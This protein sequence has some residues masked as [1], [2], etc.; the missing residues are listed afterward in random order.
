M[1]KSFS[2][3][4]LGLFFSGVFLRLF[5]SPDMNYET[6]S[7]SVLLASK[8]LF[9]IG[10]YTIPPISLT[11]YG[12]NYQ[13]NPGWAVGYSLLLSLLFKFFGYSESIARLT[14]ILIT[15]SV[16]PI[17]G[18]VGYRL[19]DRKVGILAAIL[20]TISPILLCINGRILTANMGYSML[21]LSISFLILGTIT[22]KQGMEFISSEEL[23]RSKKHLFFFLLSF[24]FFGFTLS[25]RDDFGMFAPVYLVSIWGITRHKYESPFVQR[26]KNYTQFFGMAV[27]FTLIGFSPNLYY[28]Y[29]T[30]GKIFASSHFEYGGRLSLEYF[31]EGSSGAMGLPGW[32]VILLSIIVFAFPVVS[33]FLIWSKSKAGAIL[34]SMLV[35]MIIPLLLINGSYAVS[36]SGASGR[37]VIPLIPLGSIATAILLNGQDMLHRLYYFGF[38]GCLILWHVILIYPPSIFFRYYPQIAYITHYSPWYNTQNYINYPHPIRTTLQWV[39]NN[40]SVDSIVLSD[41]DFYQYFFYAN[42][43]VMNRDFLKDIKTRL[44]KRKIFFVEDHRVIKNP[45]LLR[46]WQ[47][48]LKAN[49]I[50]LKERNTFP[51]FSPNRGEKTLKIYE[52]IINDE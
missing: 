48:K 24:I 34:G 6:D 37:Y 39:T 23:I 38:L 29:K 4:L 43:D 19:Q 40:T 8:N 49:Q 30:Y 1:E 9:E 18:I 44:M 2:L 12:G 36:S 35:L 10:E 41:Y 26:I 28:N 7:F 22:R 11:D 16:I 45:D 52:L 3:F 33:V 47:N 21:T 15:S 25:S 13:T 50:S 27:V 20:V 5:F 32:A 51:F 31:L 17:I 46:N 42:R 14:T